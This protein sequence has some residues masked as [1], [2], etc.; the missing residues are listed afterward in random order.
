MRDDLLRLVFTCCHPSL[1]L[2]ARV[3]LSLRTLGGSPPRRSPGAA[4]A[5]GHHGQAADQDEAEDRPGPH[6]LP[7]AARRRATRSLPA[8]LATVYLIF[9]EGYA[10]SSGDLAVRSDLVDEAI[11]L[12]RLLCELMP[13]EASVIGL[14]ALVLLQDSRRSARVDKDG[15]W[16]CWPTRT[17][18]CGTEKIVEGVRLVGKALQRSPD[19]PDPTGA[20]GDRGL[21]R[22]RPR[23]VDTDW[24]AIVSWYDVLRRSPT[25][26]WCGS[27]GPPR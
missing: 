19:R 2:D 17:G 15:G 14:L 9:N 11:R 4:G 3:A 20:G 12:A 16:C 6:P 13:D 24:P 22:A 26:P 18:R 7:G 5:R 21:S 1:S 27:T 10:A 8:V 23:Y 25:H